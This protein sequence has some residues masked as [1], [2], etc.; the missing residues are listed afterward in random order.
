MRFFWIEVVQVSTDKS[1]SCFFAM[2][3][4]HTIVHHRGKQACVQK[5][6]FNPTWYVFYVV[7]LKMILNGFA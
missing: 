4:D 7:F 1:T 6:M 5:N 2:E 3:L